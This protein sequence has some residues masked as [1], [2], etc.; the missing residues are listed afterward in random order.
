[1]RAA[2]LSGVTAAAMSS[3][4]GCSSDPTQGYSFTPSFRS[5]VD[6][7]NVQMFGNTTYIHGIESDLTSAVITEV[8]RQSPMKVTTKENAASTLTGT[9]VKSEMRSLSVGRNTG[10]VEELAL[11]LTVQFEWRDNRTGKVLVA[12]RNFAASD[13]F[14]PAQGVGES[15]E[16]GQMATIARLARDIVGEL[17]SGW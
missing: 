17:R 12:R 8:Q 7:I 14:I 13:S 1:M 2:L 10:I 6:S 5:D 3:L 16:L 15:L 11:T 9:L 4:A